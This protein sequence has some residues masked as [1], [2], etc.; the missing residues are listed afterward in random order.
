[1]Q[2]ASQPRTINEARTLANIEARAKTLVADGYKLDPSPCTPGFFY[3]SK[4]AAGLGNFY[5][6][7]VVSGYCDCP[8]FAHRHT[9][10]H[11]IA[12]RAEWE[13]EA[14]MI[15]EQEQNML[16]AELATGCDAE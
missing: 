15:A 12:A 2:T 16:D 7:D 8:S 11:L 13:A 10:K 14:A 3:V 9:C 6:V 5:I 4:P 1:M